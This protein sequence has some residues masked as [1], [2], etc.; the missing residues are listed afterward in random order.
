MLISKEHNFAFYHTNKCGGTSISQLLNTLGVKF[1]QVGKKHTPIITKDYDITGLTV[2]ATIRDPFA[3]I[4]SM[5]S[6]GKD[7]SQ[8]KR[9]KDLSFKDFLYDW[10]FGKNQYIFWPIHEH[11]F[12]DGQLP[13]NI[14]PVKIE[15]C[16]SKW[17]EIIEKHFGKKVSRIPWV[18]TSTHGEPIGYYSSDMKADVAKKEWWAV[19]RYTE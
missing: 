17:P 4:V 13:E 14:V 15:E 18:N 16:N 11:L 5:Y 9:F 2:Y 3:R 10:Y 1:E 7:F 19:E 8:R 12:F 6:Y